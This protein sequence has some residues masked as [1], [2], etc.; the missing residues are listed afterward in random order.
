MVLTGRQ[1]NGPA[2][3]VYIRRHRRHSVDGDLNQRPIV[4][5]AGFHDD[6]CRH[7]RNS[8]FSGLVSACA[9]IG[10]AVTQII[11]LVEQPSV[12]GQIHPASLS[13]RLRDDNIH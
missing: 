3:A 1:E 10:N 8:F 6:P 12:A 7:I 2:E 4:P 5:I 9:E 11:P 13:E